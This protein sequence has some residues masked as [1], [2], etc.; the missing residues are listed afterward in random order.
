MNRVTDT[1]DKLVLVRT[2]MSK[3]VRKIKRYKLPGIK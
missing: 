1:E 2:G 3:N